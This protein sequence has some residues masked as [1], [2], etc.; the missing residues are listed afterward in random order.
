MNWHSAT[1]CDSSYVMNISK[2][3]LFFKADDSYSKLSESCDSIFQYN[4]TEWST[5]E[6]QLN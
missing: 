1:M 3:I 5:Q 2:I 6:S 4:D